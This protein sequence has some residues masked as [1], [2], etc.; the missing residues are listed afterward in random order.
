MP[1]LIRLHLSPT[2]WRRQLDDELVFGFSK[3]LLSWSSTVLLL[4]ILVVSLARPN[5]PGIFSDGRSRWSTKAA[6]DRWIQGYV[7]QRW[8]IIPIPG[9]TL[10]PGDVLTY[11]AI[12][13]TRLNWENHGDISVCPK[14][15]DEFVVELWPTSPLTQERVINRLRPRGR[16]QVVPLASSF[17]EWKTLTKLEDARRVSIRVSP[18]CLEDSDVHEGRFIVE[19]DGDGLVTRVLGYD[20]KHLITNREIHAIQVE[21]TDCQNISRISLML[22]ER[23]VT[24]RG[25]YS[26][27]RHSSPSQLSWNL[28]TGLVM[29]GLLLSAVDDEGMARPDRW[30]YPLRSHLPQAQDTAAAIAFPWPDYSVRLVETIPSNATGEGQGSER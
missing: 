8:R 12:A 28:R 4:W 22:N 17:V 13:Q 21:A 16:I 29:D 7:I 10:D 25:R 30:Q 14:S 2:S 15:I 18:D 26:D 23:G 24:A 6:Q 19:R 1:Q 11:A 5:L 27:L 9:R 3:R 20:S